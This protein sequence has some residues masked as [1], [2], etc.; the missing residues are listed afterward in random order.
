M[1]SVST[2][3]QVALSSPLRRLFDYTSNQ[4]IPAGTRVSV[5]FGNQK[6]LVGIVIAHSAHSTTPADKLRPIHGVLDKEPAIDEELMALCQWCADYYHYP[7]GEVLHLALPAPLRKPE[8]SAIPTQLQWQ[9]TEAGREVDP[10]T[11]IRSI[12]QREAMALLRSSALLSATMAKQ[13]DISSSTLKALK[14]KGWVSSESV[15]LSSAIDLTAS[16]ATTKEQALPLNDEQAQALATISIDSFTPYLLDGVTGSGKTEV[17]LQAIARALEKGLQ[18]L[19]LVPEIGLTPQTISRFERRFAVPMAA[20]HSGLSDKQRLQIWQHAKSGQLRIIIGTRSSIFS[21]LPQLGLIVVDEEHDLSYKQQ[22]GVRYSARDLAIVR[23]QKRNIPLILGSATPSLESLHNALS[24]RYQ[25]LIL[26]QRVNHQAL[27]TLECIN[28]QE[29]GL[30]E[31]AITAIE[32]TLATGQQVLVFINRRGFAPTLCCQDCGW[33]SQCLL[34]DS[35][36]TLHRSQRLQQLH[37]HHCD[38]RSPVPSQCPHCHSR[39]LEAL[40]TGTQRSEQALEQRFPETPIIRIDRDSVS[41]KG[42]LEAALALINS[43][44]ACILVGTQM[45]AKGHHFANLGLAVILGLDSGFFSSDFRGAERM[46]QLLTQV[47]GRVGREQQ[48]S[49]VLI[50]TRFADHP[51][52]QQLLSAGYHD[53]ALQL[54]AERQLSAMPPFE[55]IAAIRCHAQQPQLA[56]QFL[57]QVRRRAEA[58]APPHNGLQYLGPFPATMEKRNNRYHYLLQIKTRHRPERQQLL[59]QLCEQIDTL[60]TTKGLHW[61]IDVDPQDC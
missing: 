27:P 3:I 57:Q 51:L 18:A 10:A 34:C 46:G 11:S 23:A 44:Q 13:A 21:P 8:P 61:L 50:Q 43:G 20:L 36:M 22:E 33:I 48:H 32:Q 19:V 39:R 49:K 9:L 41:R 1:H 54:L 7:L 35:R 31:P 16:D 47:S 55:H 5:P 37:C 17:Y 2:I 53:F 45:L 4:V 60:R 25:H 26:R 6:A 52:L 56:Q 14:D 38:S 30:A 12:K 40:G 15:E 58:I 42:Q 29:S 28:T 59:K 24:G